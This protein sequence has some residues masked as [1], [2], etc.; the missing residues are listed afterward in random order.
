MPFAVA[1]G[2]DPARDPS[3]DARRQRAVLGEDVAGRP[4][5]RGAGG[6]RRTTPGTALVSGSEAKTLVRPNRKASAHRP[7]MEASTRMVSTPRGISGR[8]RSVAATSVLA[9]G[10]SGAGIRPHG[11]RP[12]QLAADQH[13]WATDGQG[14]DRAAARRQRQ[15]GGCELVAQ[16]AVAV[17]GGERHLERDVALVHAVQA[18]PPAPPG[19]DLRR[20]GPQ[21]HLRGGCDDEVEVDVVRGDGVRAGGQ[22]DGER[23]AP[24]RK[25]LRAARRSAITRPEASGNSESIGG[26]A[27]TWSGFQADDPGGDPVDHRGRV[28]H[29]ETDL[30]V[31][32]RHDVEQPGVALHSH[33]TALRLVALVGIRAALGD[34]R[35]AHPAP[36][37]RGPGTRRVGD[38]GRRSRPRKGPAPCREPGS[39]CG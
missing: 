8:C 38:G 13:P 12:V 22:L 19:P 14:R 29:V 17:D 30:G 16:R 26:S 18:E 11:E 9:S 10:A 35:A 6:A 1:G 15:G 31:T 27:L 3:A 37:E 24:R 36:G 20:V 5:R 4:A 34:D 21:R 2:G 7:T 28:D 23:V 25:A 33:G 39:R 32:A